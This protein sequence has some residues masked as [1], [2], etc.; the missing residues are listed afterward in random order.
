MSIC[1]ATSVCVETCVKQDIVIA[2]GFLWW[3]LNKSN[4]RSTSDNSLHVLL[5]WWKSASSVVQ[6]GVDGVLLS[7]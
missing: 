5:G 4:K 1:C 6:I 7:I 2:M 3:A